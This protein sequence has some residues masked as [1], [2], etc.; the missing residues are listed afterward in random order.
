[1]NLWTKWMRWLCIGAVFTV[2]FA[3]L[4]P[5]PGVQ[6]QSPAKFEPA[7]GVYIGGA[8]LD[9]Q[10]GEFVSDAGKQP[11]L[12]EV[13]LYFPSDD[14]ANPSNRPERSLDTMAREG[15][16]PVITWQPQTYVQDIAAGKYDGYIRQV[17]RE[18]KQFGKP[19]FIRYAHEANGAWY[20]WSQYPDAVKS[21][22]QRIYKIFQEE[23]ATNVAF[24]WCPNFDSSGKNNW[25]QYYPGDNYVD[26]VGVDFYNWAKWP[27]TFDAMVK[28]VYMEFASRKPI[29]IGETASAENF[30]PAPGFNNPATQN[31]S[32][33][34]TDMFT[35]MNTKYPRIKAFIWFDI[36]KED[37]WKIRSSQSSLQAFRAGVAN[38]RYLS[39][40]DT[41]STAPSVTPTIK[42]TINPTATPIATPTIK[43]VPAQYSVNQTHRQAKYNGKYSPIEKFVVTRG[44]SVEQSVYYQ[45]NG[46][47]SDSYTASVSGLPAAWCKITLYGK[48]V[49]APGE[50]RYG[51]IVITPRSPG[52]YTFTVKVASNVKP[53]VYDTET[54]TMYVK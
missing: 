2:L 51:N 19:V 25:L 54:Y 12:K 4:T 43:P 33:W 46:S 9:S 28:D 53:G 35:A 21:S 20:N 32:Q 16:T 8:T 37:N 26:W 49:V 52:T 15:V 7:S 36:T 22:S 13:Y 34:I 38:P 10:W 18:C 14:F 47:A 1:M 24:V 42:P 39:K 31:K 5:I 27:R 40:V 30:T 44:T 50:G 11:A 23:G 29:M 3:S 48:A 6:A 17:A 45:N 41:G